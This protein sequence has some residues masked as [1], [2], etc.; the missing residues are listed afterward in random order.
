MASKEVCEGCGVELHPVYLNQHRRECAPYGEWSKA[1]PHPCRKG[2][3]VGFAAPRA[4][5]NHERIC[6]G[7][8]APVTHG[9]RLCGG[10]YTGA[11]TAHLNSCLGPPSP[12]AVPDDTPPPTD[13]GC[14][15]GYA[16]P[17]TNAAAVHR[18][19]CPVW[20]VYSKRLSVKCEG[21][22]AG[23]PDALGKR[24]HARACPK[25]VEWRKAQDTAEKVHPCPS[26]GELMRGPQLG[27]H[28]NS[29]PGPWTKAD[30]D[31]HRSRSHA[32]RQGLHTPAARRL[33][34]FVECGECGGRF[35]RL[36]SHLKHAHGLTSKQHRDKHGGS[37]TSLHTK[38]RA[39]HTF[40]RNYGVDHPRK[41]ATIN[42]RAEEARVQTM[43]DRYGAPTPME[44]GLIPTSRTAPERAVEAMNLP[45]LCYTGN[46]AYW[47]NVRASDGSWKPRNP[48][49]VWY[50]SDQAARVAEGAPPN[51][52]RTYR[53][54]EVLGC[55]W[56]GEGRTGLT[57]EAY[58]EARTAEYASVGVRAC[59][60]WES[61]VLAS[62]DEVR[63][64]LTA[65]LT[66]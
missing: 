12:P 46:H 27:Q 32:R 44:A 43:L 58:V 53:C 7:T 13:L 34:D 35:R 55:Y 29:C 18:S 54:V 2:C 28:V 31:G 40:V 1:L 50:D 15:C 17:S 9:C 26:C 37:T 56:H 61:E 23:F 20:W 47:V 64:R 51:E 22:G 59:F 8:V 10:R 62:P 3:G 16:G 52:V 42:Q 36:A 38:A 6:T 39:K 19:Q 48:D 4:R 21:C 49:F 11:L 25:W 33:F 24:S 66:P 65:F 14:A 41:V 5:A 60:V 57:P 45:G 63:E 30:W